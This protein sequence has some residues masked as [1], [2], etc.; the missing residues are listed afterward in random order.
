MP[1]RRQTP[2]PCP[3]HPGSTVWF[4]GTYGTAARRR[5][6]YRC[7]PADGEPPHR[8]S[9]QLTPRFFSYT[10]AEIARALVAVGE[11]MSYRGAAKVVQDGRRERRAGPDGNSVADW[12]EIFAPAVFARF[13]KTSWPPAVLLDSLPFRMRSVDA[14]GRLLP[15]DVPAFYVLGA[16]EP[17]SSGLVMLQA[18]PGVYPGSAQALWEEFLRSL[19]G[20]PTHVVCDPDPDLLAAIRRVWRPAPVTLLCHTHLRLQLREVLRDEGIPPGEPLSNVGERSLDRVEAWH[21]FVEFHRPRRLRK[22][23]RWISRHEAAISWQLQHANTSE[24]NTDA[25]TEKLDLLGEH[26]S[27]RRANLRNRERTNRLLML[28]QLE[29]NGR[30]DETRYARIIEEELIT[31][32]GRAHRRRAIVDPDG[33]SLRP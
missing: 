22:L 27:G 29:W 28:V 30:A 9:E 16:H 8:F 6:R 3:L 4:D 24:T 1:T 13:A 19:D 5:R 31:H 23:E 2:P 20:A 15:E 33:T 7:L 25:L 21:E 17:G 18:F 32:A 12:V 11:G 14:T 10:A 26:L